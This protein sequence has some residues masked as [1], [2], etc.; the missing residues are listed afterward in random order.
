LFQQAYVLNS[1][2]KWLVYFF[3][4]NKHGW[5]ALTA[6]LELAHVLRSLLKGPVCLWVGFAYGMGQQLEFYGAFK[7][8]HPTAICSLS[9]FEDLKP[10]WVKRLK[11]WN[12]CCCKY[13]QEVTE[14]MIALDV[15]RTDKH[16]VHKDCQYEL[17]R[18]RV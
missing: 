14:L 15:M 4:N 10:W 1:L 2:L 3:W 8:R 6:S 9:S 17:W 7:T 18:I 16:E 12:T 13:H 11:L 5:V